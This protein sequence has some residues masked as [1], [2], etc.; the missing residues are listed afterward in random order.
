MIALIPISVLLFVVFVKYYQNKNG[1]ETYN[2]ILENFEFELSIF[3]VKTEISSLGAKKNEFIFNTAN[4]HFTNN[5]IIVYGFSEFL[6]FKLNKIP[7]IL[8]KEENFKNFYGCG[9]INIEPKMFNLHSFEK[10]VFVEFGEATWNEQCASMRF[11]G[12][13]EEDKKRIE[14]LNLDFKKVHK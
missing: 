6:G 7:F 1:Q 14:K 13:S 10:A 9:L 11:L 8:C 3:K 5:A 4:L 2:K 12:I